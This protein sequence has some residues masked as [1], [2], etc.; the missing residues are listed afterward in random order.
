MGTNDST[1]DSAPDQVQIVT[2][3]LIV[4]FNYGLPSTDQFFELDE[5]L[6]EAFLEFE[7]TL[8]DGH[9]IAM[10]LSDG[11]YFFYGP[12]AD[13][14]LRLATPF[15]LRYSFMKGAECTRRYGDVHDEN[16]LEVT[17]ILGLMPS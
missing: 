2:Q 11:T 3:A 10:D 17:T 6:H 13:E 1:R 7:P 4:R 5:V 8:Y 14:L 9:E 12:D 15:L 16:A